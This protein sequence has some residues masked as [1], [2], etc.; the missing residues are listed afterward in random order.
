MLRKIPAGL[1]KALCFTSSCASN[2]NSLCVCFHAT[3]D[4]PELPLNLGTS[5]VQLQGYTSPKTGSK[6]TQEVEEISLF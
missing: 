6:F 3:A 2:P 5:E 1:R 4:L